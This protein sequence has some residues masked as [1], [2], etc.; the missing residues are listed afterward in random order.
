LQGIPCLYYGT[1]QQLHGGNGKVDELVREAL[2]GKTPNPPSPFDQTN[3]FYV[4]IRAIAQVRATQPAL[5]YGRQYFRPISG[6]GITFGVSTF[7]PGVVAFSRILNDEEVVVVAN[8]GTAAVPNLFVIVD[9][10]LNPAGTAFTVAFS[11]KSTPGQPQ[12]VVQLGQGG[13]LTIHEVDGS[14]SKGPANAIRVSLQAREAQILVKP[15]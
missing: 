13:T 14:T 7:S 15:I 8:V 4:A 3:L 6:D 9:S 2:W 11:N 12:N 5:R 1:E 10:V